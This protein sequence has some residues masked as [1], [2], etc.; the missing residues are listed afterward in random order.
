MTDNLCRDPSVEAST[1]LSE[2]SDPDTWY[3]HPWA[4]SDKGIEPGYRIATDDARTGSQSIKSGGM[5]FAPADIIIPVAE[6]DPGLSTPRLVSAPCSPGDTI[7]M[8]FWYKITIS[9]GPDQGGEAEAGCHVFFYNALG[10]NVSNELDL[11][12]GRIRDSWTQVE[13][14]FTVPPSAAWVQARFV[15]PSLSVPNFPAETQFGWFDDFELYIEGDEPEPEPSSSLGD[16]VRRGFRL[17][18]KRTELER[19]MLF[20]ERQLE[21][22]LHEHGNSDVRQVGFRFPRRDFN[23]ESAKM[24]NARYLQTQLEL[25]LHDH[26]EAEEEEGGAHL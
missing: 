23:N 11:T 10:S 17:P 3:D 5:H 26:V 20:V 25:Y 1:D 24:E 2:L 6:S 12:G 18:Y 15:P 19:N 13:S 21:Q 8:R 7:T 9:D 4:V 16:L 14:T 22:Y